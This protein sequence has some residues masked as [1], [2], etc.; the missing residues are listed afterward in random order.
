MRKKNRWAIILLACFGSITSCSDFLDP[1]L[2]GSMSEAEVFENRAY[3]NGLLNTVY[4]NVP[5]QY[6]IALDC[7]T[8]NAV[9]N[10]IGSTYY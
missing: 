1:M 5:T 3:F 6:N 4:S 7:A 2:D 9:T 10:D 8:D